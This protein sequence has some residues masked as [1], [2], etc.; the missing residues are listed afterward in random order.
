MHCHALGC[1]YLHYISYASGTSFVV[2]THVSNYNFHC[3]WWHID[4]LCIACTLFVHILLVFSNIWS[5]LI[6]F[7]LTRF[8]SVTFNFC[9][10]LSFPILLLCLSTIVLTSWALR[11]KCRWCHFMPWRVLNLF[12]SF[13]ILSLTSWGSRFWDSSAQ[14][15]VRDFPRIIMLIWHNYLVLSIYHSS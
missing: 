7:L 9:T 12:L 10:T 15:R 2:V 13:C 1:M 3:S 4:I 8:L 5:W 6:L 14:F 11:L